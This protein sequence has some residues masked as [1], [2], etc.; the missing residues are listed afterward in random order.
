MKTNLNIIVMAMLPL[1]LAATSC[2]PVASI[3]YAYDADAKT[4]TIS[5]TGPM[6]DLGRFEI[7]PWNSYQNKTAAVVIE[8]GITSIGDGN[9]KH[10]EKLISVSLPESLESIG[11]ET[12]MGT[13][14]VSITIPKSVK[15]IGHA[16]FLG[17]KLS[18][19]KIP[20]SVSKIGILAFESP[21][22][23]GDAGLKEVVV[24]WKE[25]PPFIRMKPNVDTGAQ[26]ALG[27]IF[28]DV[29][30]SVLKVPK[31]T[32]ALYESTPEWKTFGSIVEE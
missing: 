28:G 3:S 8:E 15:S 2:K 11:D 18:Y 19:L 13:G 4:L 9:F 24:E 14:I 5:G 10:F 23:A 12:F 26:N 22:K 30:K 25:S 20:A 16:A 17:N 21:T 6:P 27:H 7:S 31:G 29:S 1:L 32:K